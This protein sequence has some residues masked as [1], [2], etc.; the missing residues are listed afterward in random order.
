MDDFSRIYDHLAW[1]FGPLARFTD[2]PL[3]STVFVS[4]SALSV[5]IGLVSRLLPWRPILLVI[6]WTLACVGHPL[7][8]RALLAAHHAHIQPRERQL[9]AWLVKWSKNEF[10]IEPASET[11]E[12]EIFE[13]QRHSR[14]G[15]W[16]AWIF[17]LSPYDPLEAE[18]I[19]GRRP[20]GA[21]FL[22]DV[23]PPYSWSWSALQWSIDLLSLDWVEER[24]ISAVEVEMEGE[25]WVY[26][27]PLQCHHHHQQEERH[28]P[29][30]DESNNDIEAPTSHGQGDRWRRR[31]WTRLVKR[32]L[33]E[34]PN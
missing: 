6:G 25:R 13:L 27:L 20:T 16:E 33:A 5:I 10:A 2:E 24:F 31:R 29:G 12:V 23:Q 14:T 17:S 32:Q 4:L 11:G 22:G 30:A 1:M 21:R 18:R 26:D 3:S 7:V 8:Q 28:Q 34:P 15:E 19:C 9:R